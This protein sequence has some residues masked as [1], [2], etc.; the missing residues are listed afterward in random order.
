MVSVE[1]AARMVAE[2]PEVTEGR[3]YG[4]RT[5]FVGGR[6]FAWERPFSKADI[7][8]FGDTEPPKGPILALTVADLVEKEAILAANQRG[9]FTIAHFDGYAAILVALDAVSKPILRDAILDAW[10]AVAPKSLAD[11]YLGGL[12]RPGKPANG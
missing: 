3:R 6:G 5:W 11:G 12:K 1:N 10:L 9:F 7:K 4:N 2:L 8:R